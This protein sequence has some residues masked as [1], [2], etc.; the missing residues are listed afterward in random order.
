MVIHRRRI[1]FQIISMSLLSK[2]HKSYDLFIVINKI[3][4][5]FARDAEILQWTK[6]KA[7]NVGG[8]GL[9]LVPHDPWN[10]VESD[11]IHSD[12]SRC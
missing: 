3:I 5:K 12:S 2:K 9:I 4:S 6:Q 11:L 10:I 8:L 1:K 7:L